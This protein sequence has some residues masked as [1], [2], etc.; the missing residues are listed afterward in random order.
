MQKQKLHYEISD[1][2]R[3]LWWSSGYN[4]ILLM[5]GTQTQSL[6]RDLNSICCNQDRA[7]SNKKINPSV[8]FWTHFDQSLSEQIYLLLHT[9]L[10]M[11]ACKYFFQ[12]VKLEMLISVL[13]TDF[14]TKLSRLPGTI[15][16]QSK[17]L[18]V[19]L[20]LIIIIIIMI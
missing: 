4:S 3:L 14:I 2:L 6:V 15:N 18:V 13:L 1:F 19:L 10:C 17:K 12:F 11:T 8:I 16:K 5:Q 7:Q 9:W 20:L